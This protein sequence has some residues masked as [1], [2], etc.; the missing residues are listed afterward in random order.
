[1]LRDGGELSQASAAMISKVAKFSEVHLAL[2][3]NSSHIDKSKLKCTHCGQTRHVKEQCFQI[4]GYPDWYKDKK[5]VKQQ[6]ISKGKVAVA[7]SETTGE[8]STGQLVW[9]YP[10]QFRKPDATQAQS[11]DHAKITNENNSV[12]L[13]AA[14]SCRNQD[15]FEQ[16]NIFH[17]SEKI[18]EWVID[19]GATDHMTFSKKDFKLIKHTQKMVF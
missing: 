2:N 12:A 16:G 17:N 18:K 3:K 7:T 4:V 11:A 10:N 5:R 15:N 1:M 8:R 6:V 13:H 14:G 19:S 9:A